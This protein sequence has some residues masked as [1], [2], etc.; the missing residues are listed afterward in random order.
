MRTALI[1]CACPSTLHNADLTML[2]HSGHAQQAT[3][4]AESLFVLDRHAV[5]D[6]LNTQTHALAHHQVYCIY[7]ILMRA[8]RHEIDAFE[9]DPIYV[10]A[11]RS[12]AACLFSALIGLPLSFRFCNILVW[13]SLPLSCMFAC[14]P[15]SS[16]IDRFWLQFI[17]F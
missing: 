4:L 17:T 10:R 9:P 8:H 15:T 13:L 6:N 1:S 2:R 16:L 3:T 5:R 7:F 11:N 12:P 14:K